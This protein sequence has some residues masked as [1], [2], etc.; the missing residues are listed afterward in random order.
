MQGSKELS[1]LSSYYYQILNR[2]LNNEAISIIAIH[3]LNQEMTNIIIMTASF[4]AIKSLIIMRNQEFVYGANL[5]FIQ[6]RMANIA[7][8]LQ[9]PNQ[10][11]EVEDE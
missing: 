1:F 4:H 9:N 3:L 5:R 2:I 11:G 6:G 7:V 10:R 8:H